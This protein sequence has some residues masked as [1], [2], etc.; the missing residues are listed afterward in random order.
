MTNS[1][2]TTSLLKEIAPTG[3]L[4]VGINLGN[5]LLASLNA[6]QQPQGITVDLAHEL[7]QRLGLSPE[8]TTFAKAGDTVDAIKNQMVDLVFVAIDPVR[9]QDVDYSSAYVQ[10]EGAYMVRETSPLTKNEEVDQSNN[11]VVVGK[12]SAYDLFLTRELKHAQIIRAANSQAVVDE[13]MSQQLEVAAG[14][15]QQLEEDAKR[16]SG[17]RILPG[18][19]MVIHQAMGIPKGRPMALS[20]ISEF[21]NTMKASGFV[22]EAIQRH[23]IQGV[24]VAEA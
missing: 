16:Y 11:R 2:I 13:F 14:V 20:Y 4:L 7:A 18:R 10:I 23:G 21:V 5:P 19:F 15:K 3:K 24:S 22:Q 8:F 1:A 17:L 12:A 6:Q 9:G